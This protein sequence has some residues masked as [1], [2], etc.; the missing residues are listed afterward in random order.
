[1]AIVDPIMVV[2]LIQWWLSFGSREARSRQDRS[3]SGVCPVRRPC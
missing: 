1:M 2:L 3:R